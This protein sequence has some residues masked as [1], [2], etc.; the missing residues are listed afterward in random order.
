MK[1]TVVIPTY[2][3]KDNISLLVKQILNTAPQINIL[4][5]DDN[6]PDGTGLIADKLAS[7]NPEIKVLH[8]PSKEGLG[9]AYAAA[10]KILLSSSV[11]CIITMDAD[12]SHDPAILPYFLK[13]IEKHDIIIGSRYIKGISVL[14]W[15]LSRLVLSILANKF[16]RFTTGL[17]LK[18]CTSG[19]GCYRRQALQQLDFKN[20]ASGSY[21]FLFELKYKLFKKSF[22][23]IEIPIIFTERRAGQPKMSWKIISEAFFTVFKLRFLKIY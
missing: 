4:I 5:V 16:I 1:A 19:F 13:E 6:S 9:R 2:N 15:P 11:E 23:I 7:D 14:N 22:D 17:P 8:R 12:F 3:E 20:F 10:F 18:D 21:A